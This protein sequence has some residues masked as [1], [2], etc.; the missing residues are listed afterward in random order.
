MASER[1]AYF[2]MESVVAPN[3]EYRALIAKEGVHGYYL[4]DWTW[5][6]DLKVAEQIAAKKNLALGLDD[7]AA[8]KIVL[9][10]MRPLGAE[11]KRRQARARLTR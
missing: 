9:S 4:T 3:G 2:V 10:T 8:W 11:P 5:G 7:K 6:K 1:V